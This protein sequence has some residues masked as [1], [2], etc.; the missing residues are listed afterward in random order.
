[1]N[2]RKSLALI[3]LLAAACALLAACMNDGGTT[4]SATPAPTANFAP[5]ATNGYLGT[6]ANDGGTT[7][8]ARKTMQG[9][10]LPGTEIFAFSMVRRSTV[11]CSFAMDGVG[12]K[13]ARNTMGMPVEMPPRMPPQ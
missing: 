2:I 8:T 1:M 3:L 6:G 11:S 9:S 5:E 7:G 4:L 13:A 12:L 10:C